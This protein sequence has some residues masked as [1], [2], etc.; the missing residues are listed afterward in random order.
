MGAEDIPFDRTLAART[1]EMEILSAA[2][3]R[4]IANN[5]G[6]FTFT[7]TCT[8]VVGRGAVAVI[9]P[10]PADASHVA[11]LM[12]GLRGETVRH[13]LV[14]HTHPDHAPAARC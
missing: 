3:R 1:G 11:A 5:A 8:Y 2:L 7:G 12:E 4:I 14:T 10:G 9:D 6:P 13:I